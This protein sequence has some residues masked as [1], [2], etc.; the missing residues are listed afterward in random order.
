M[1][2]SINVSSCGYYI[3]AILGTTEGNKRG[4]KA[5]RVR[6]EGVGNRK[7]HGER[8]RQRGER[9][10]FKHYLDATLNKC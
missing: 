4:Q 5:E 9:E 2:L 6:E 10:S 7:G 3:Y 8:K 1:Y